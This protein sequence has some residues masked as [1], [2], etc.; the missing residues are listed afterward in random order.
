MPIVTRR[1]SNEKP[2]SPSLRDGATFKD[3][4]DMLRTRV[5]RLTSGMVWCEDPA[6]GQRHHVSNVEVYATAVP[7]EYKVY[8][9]VLL[10]RSRLD[11]KRKLFSVLRE[12][13]WR[14]NGAEWQLTFRKITLDD[15]GV[16]DSNLNLFF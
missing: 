1:L 11:G 4:L 2:R 13:L 8:S 7:D 3:N 6:N 10:Y 14:R 5:V 9:T 16:Q 12:D 15:D